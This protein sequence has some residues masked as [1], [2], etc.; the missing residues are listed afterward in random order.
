MPVSHPS[1]EG[2]WIC[3]CGIQR[4][5]GDWRNKCGV[6]DI[7]V[8]TVPMEWVRLSRERKS[9]EMRRWFGTE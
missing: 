6:Y 5:A 8:I 4:G 7:H 9:N 1:G 2:N 3:R